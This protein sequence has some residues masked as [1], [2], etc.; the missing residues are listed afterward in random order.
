MDIN[1]MKNTMQKVFARLTVEERL[2]L[3]KSRMPS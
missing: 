1:I 2:D 3:V